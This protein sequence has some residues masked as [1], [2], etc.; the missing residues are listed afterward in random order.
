MAEPD[1]DASL[2]SAALKLAK[3]GLSVLPLHRS[4]VNS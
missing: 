1:E 3:A 2:M 4:R